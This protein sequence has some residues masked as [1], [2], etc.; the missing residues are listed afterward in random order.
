MWVK[1]IQLHPI[2]NELW[3][4]EAAEPL[5]EEEKGDERDGNTTFMENV[6]GLWL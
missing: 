1:D 3:V 2:A 6:A 4:L 5:W